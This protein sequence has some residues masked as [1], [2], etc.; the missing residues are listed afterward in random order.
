MGTPTSPTSSPATTSTTAAAVDSGSSDHRL[1]AAPAQFLRGSAPA[2]IPT[3]ADVRHHRRARPLAAAALVILASTASANPEPIDPDSP[4]AR[5]DDGSYVVPIMP[6]WRAIDAA[7]ALSAQQPGRVLSIEADPGAFAADWTVV[8]SRTLAAGPTPATVAQVRLRVASWNLPGDDHVD[9][10]KVRV[11]SLAD[12]ASQELGGTGLTTWGGSLAFL[13]GGVFHVELL[14]R[15]PRHLWADAQVTLSTLDVLDA[16]TPPTLQGRSICGTVDDRVPD[17]DPIIAR[18]WPSICTA[19][20]I[21]DFNAGLLTAGHCGPATGAV[22]QFNVPLSTSGG[23]AVSPP[24]E[25]QYPVDSTSVQR[26]SGGTGQDWSYFGILPN[27]LGQ[28]ARTRQG[29]GA[30][31]A[32][33]APSLAGTPLRLAGFGTTASPISPS[34]NV[35][36]KTHAGPLTL[37]DGTRL[38]HG[39]DTTG[40]NSGSAIM[41]DA[42]PGGAS[43]TIVGI[44]SHAGCSATG[45]SNVGTVIQH[46]GLQA[47]LASPRGVCAS[48]ATALAPNAYEG[49]GDV[50]LATDGANN[51]GAVRVTPDGLGGEPVGGF[52]RRAVLPRSIQALATISGGGGGGGG[53]SARVVAIATGNEAF[54]IVPRTGEVVLVGGLADASGEAVAQITG[55]AT[56]SDG[57]TFAVAQATSRLYELNTTT[58]TLTSLGVVGAPGVTRIGALEWDPVAGVLLALDDVPGGST[59]LVTIVPPAAGSN[60]PESIAWAIV[61]SL[62]AGA[63]DCNGLV[64][65]PTGGLYTVDVSTGRLLRIDRSTGGATFVANVQG[66]VLGGYGMAWVDRAALEPACVGDFDGDGGITAAD[67]GAFFGVFESGSPEADVDGDGGITPSD[68]A[69]F[70]EAFEVGC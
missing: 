33:A 55:L 47:A 53:T 17:Q 69:R 44:H 19:T 67:I 39:V 61:G 21:E 56:A 9:G 52:A 25:D 11:T 70:F 46:P 10:A 37:I 62:G 26:L 58:A 59:R 15:G 4:D 63:T 66:T 23:A 36:L 13:N 8:A 16:P 22:V 30:T 43:R 32:P 49:L 64:R 18:I 20:L 24:P 68:V 38:R 48:G 35:A 27:S 51:I 65:T 40:G 1:R 45:G 5:D 3:G 42:G 50:W 14:V 29:P 34:W 6:A 54:T 2:A 41:L 28:S 12:G 60:P 57:R 31:L 7:S